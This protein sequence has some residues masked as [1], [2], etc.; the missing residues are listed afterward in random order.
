MT[1]TYYL[2]TFRNLSQLSEYPTLCCDGMEIV[3][4]FS[5]SLLTSYTISY[6]S[7]AGLQFEHYNKMAEQCDSR[8]PILL[9]CTLTKI[10]FSWI[11]HVYF[12]FRTS[13]SLDLVNMLY[14]NE[15][16]FRQDSKWQDNAYL[17]HFVLAL[18]LLFGDWSQISRDA[19]NESSNTQKITIDSHNVITGT[20]DIVRNF[21]RS[22]TKWHIPVNS[23]LYI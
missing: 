5:N 2:L 15:A 4:V 23:V 18:G 8:C 22:I 14:T 19:S 10:C 11:N 17:C 16:D 1:G 9:S 21:M 3:C 20:L 12:K 7:H 6:R 13:F